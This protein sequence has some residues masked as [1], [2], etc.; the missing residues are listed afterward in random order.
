[1][2]GQFDKQNSSAIVVGAGL[3]GIG[4]GILRKEPSQKM[5]T[6]RYTLFVT[7][8]LIFAAFNVSAQAQPAGKVGLINL[9][10]LA[11][12]DGATR[13]INAL[14]VLD[15]EF[16]TEI[17]ALQALDANIATKTQELQGLVE[18]ANKPGS[19]VSAESL[20][21]RNYD[22]ERMKRE[23]KFKQEDLQARVNSRRQ[24]VVGPIYNEM[25]VAL[26][27]YALKNGYSIILDGGKLEENGLLMAFDAKYDVTK[28]FITFFN[29]RP[30]GTASTN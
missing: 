5:R 16:D 24:T 20:R 17:K 4:S 19:P 30:A 18:Q 7:A 21:T 14:T 23:L 25:R 22:I 10:A 28:E 11:A 13:Y 12:K 29:A 3:K 8:A 27:E 9:E 2:F 26:R 6:I 1:M 15:K